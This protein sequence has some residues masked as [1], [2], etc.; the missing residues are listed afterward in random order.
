MLLACKFH[1]TPPPVCL[2]LLLF[3]SFFSCNL[4]C[5][6]VD[7]DSL[8]SFLLNLSSSP[9]LNWI[10]NTAS[11]CCTWEGISCDQNGSVT[12]LWLPHRGLAGPISSSLTRLISLSHLNLSLNSLSGTIPPRLLSLHHLQT[13]DLSFN[14]L[15]G[16][17]PP[18]SPLDRTPLSLR[19]INVSSNS[20]TGNFP[21]INL[22]FNLTAMNAS[23][24][25]FLGPIPSSICANSSQITLLDFSS[26]K[27]SGVISQGFSGC[28]KLEVFRAGFNNLSGQIPIDL[29][30]AVGLQHLSLPFNRLS[31]RLDSE[32]M[33]RLTDITLVELNNNELS[34]EL[35]QTIGKLTNLEQ[36][37]IHANNLSGSLP[38]S[39]TNCT[40]LKSLNLRG[41]SL[42]G[43]ISAIDFSNLSQ[44]STLDLGNNN[45][46][47]SLPI[48]LYRCRSL[49]ALRLAKN[50]LRGEIQTD[51][52]ALQSLSYLSLSNNRLTNITGAFRVLARCRNLTAVLL[53]KNF[54]RET[55]PDN[56]DV[57]SVAFQNLRALSLAG[58][59]LTGGLPIWLANL[60]KLEVLD[61]SLNRLAG[62]IP[63]WLGSMPS[64]FYMDLSSN[65]LSGELPLE[66]MSLPTLVSEQAAARVDP[67]YIDL[68]VFVKP[69]NASS[70]QYNQLSDLP[71]AIYLR[72]NSLG[73]VIPPE[74]GHLQVLLV[75]DLSHN[76][77]SGK[78]PDQLSNLTNLER[79]DLSNNH[80]SGIIP[81]SL[82]SLHFLALFSVAENNL[83]GPIPS[84]GQFDTF[85]NSSFEGN[86]GL[87]GMLLL[88]PCSSNRQPPPVPP[89]YP[90]NKKL[91]VGLILSICF[92]G[93]FVIAG[94]LALWMLLSKRRV[95]P[96]G[97]DGDD[98]N[99]MKDVNLDNLISSRNSSCGP[100]NIIKDSTLVMLFPDNTDTEC[101]KDLT[102]SDILNATNNFDQANIIGCGGFGL[103]YRATLADGTKLAIKKL[104][105]DLGL[106]EREFEAEVE[107]LSMAQ[108]QN[109]VSLQGYCM[110]RSS[111]LL[112]YAYVENG[113][114]DYW[115]H[116][117]VDGGSRL[118]WPTRLRIAQGASRGLCYMHQTC[119]P[120]IVHRDIKS[121]NILLD[122]DFEARVA[123]FG[124]SRLILP[125]NTHVTTQ[126]VGTLGYI[127]PEYGQAWV[128]TLRGDIYSFGVVMLELLTGRRPI[129]VFKPKV[130]RELVGWVQQMRCEGKQDQVFDPLLRG[131]GFEGQLLHVLHVACMCVNYNPLKRPNIKDVVGWLHNIL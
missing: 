46:N 14:R 29:Y 21:S 9:P 13:L 23:N 76:N 69:H 85:P 78:I 33:V 130:S 84:G 26:N 51:M 35:P 12:H 98:G 4:A 43:E 3:L 73:G 114:L 77:F 123:D 71:P 121:S 97:G 104:S 86:S 125:Y 8:L 30:D 94:L 59:Q 105:G 90:N 82:K 124:L 42:D 10:N 47:G 74:I 20:L 65:L 108:H 120:H 57:D 70:L 118:D 41:N 81:P 115:L 24:N 87:C 64:L 93:G 106:M 75:L 99:N 60:R 127:P 102:I 89:R 16:Q 37:L 126:L 48:S 110:H 131:K 1:A 72:N 101:N 128:A 28:L 117:K 36:L 109:L 18:P 68:P 56:H 119:E 122:G 6:Q 100:D 116:E 15:S 107:A 44:L 53:S 32:R 45:F 49:T 111:R 58:C 17:F 38:W 27:F 39:L 55:V 113:S 61:L 11:D 5:T 95:N 129:E 62:S 40:N 54:L 31:G 91:L 63:R 92:G 50:R 112:I 2:S 66:L 7:H 79:L 34:G 67:S 52:Q 25:D 103:V 19:I 83:Q 88:R 80:L 96:G 22:A